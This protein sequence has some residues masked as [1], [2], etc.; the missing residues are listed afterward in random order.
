MTRLDFLKAQVVPAVNGACVSTFSSARSEILRMIGNRIAID[1]GSLKVD[2]YEDIWP[3]DLNPSILGLETNDNETFR[4]F[5]M[6]IVMNLI[7]NVQISI[8]MINDKLEILEYNSDARGIP[9]MLNPLGGFY[10]AANRQI[11][12][13]NKLIK[14]EE[15]IYESQATLRFFVKSPYSAKSDVKKAFTEGRMRQMRDDLNANS[16]GMVWLEPQEE[17]KEIAKPVEP[18]INSLVKIVEDSVKN[19]YG[20]S[21]D[22]M[23]GKATDSEL[24]YYYRMMVLPVGQTI[25]DYINRYV[26]KQE[27]FKLAYNPIHFLSPNT[28]GTLSDSLSRNE[29]FTPNEI[30][31]LMGYNLSDSENA[32]ELRN[33]NM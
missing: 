7:F 1:V 29:I 8:A 20:L 14:F 12:R 27:L 13:L 17:I 31:S 23:N 5:I 28:I 15:G 10:L 18:K 2:I 3:E 24:A 9:L 16:Y 11:A 30:R 19:I 6:R 33:R 21:D 22:L 26:F 4:E 32:N 25:Q